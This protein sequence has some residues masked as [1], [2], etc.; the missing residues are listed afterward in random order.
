MNFITKMMKT[1]TYY[2]NP[3]DI[4]S[5]DVTYTKIPQIRITTFSPKLGCQ[6]RAVSRVHLYTNVIVTMISG[7]GINHTPCLLY[8]YDS[9][10]SKEQ[11]NTERG[12]R[13]RSEFEESLE[14]YNITEDRII[15]T[16]S[17]KNYFAESPDVYEDYLNHY[18]IPKD[19]LILHDGGGDKKPLF[20]MPKV[21]IIMLY[22]KL[23]YT[24]SY[25]QMI[26]SFTGVNLHGRKDIIN[27]MIRFLR[28]YD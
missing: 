2:R 6:K 19:T 25:L 9:N 5:I 8:T 11:K 3:K 12:K 24:N 22:I 26:T 27:L 1:N 20:L 28:H 23:M 4:H 13:I 14:R 7:D 16:K 21:S 17:D 10:M 15:Y 18:D